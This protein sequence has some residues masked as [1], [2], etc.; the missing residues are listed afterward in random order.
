MH[1]RKREGQRAGRK[2]EEEEAGDERVRRREMYRG[3][4]SEIRWIDGKEDGLRAG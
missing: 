3:D 2:R 1:G 4:K